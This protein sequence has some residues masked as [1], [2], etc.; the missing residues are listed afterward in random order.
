MNEHEKN[1]FA[2][3]REIKEL[4]S[5]N[6]ISLSQGEYVKFKSTL[7]I[8]ELGE[9]IVDLKID[10]GH[11]YA[12]ENTFELFEEH[13]RKKLGGDNVVRRFDR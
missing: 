13:I 6:A 7:D 1:L 12:V 11:I 8:L 5:G 4:R 10:G 9:Y 3:Y 2:E